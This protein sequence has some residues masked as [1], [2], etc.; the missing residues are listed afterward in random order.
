[1]NVVIMNRQ[2]I[3]KRGRLP[4][5]ET[6]AVISITDVDYFFAE[7][8]NEP[9]HRLKLA[10]DDVDGDV[11]LDELSTGSTKE[12]RDALRRKYHMFS[13]E[14]AYQIAAFYWKL[15]TCGVDTLIVQCEHGQSRSAAVAA[16]IR[17]FED[18]EGISIFADDRYWP[19]KVVFRKTLKALR[20][21][22]A[23]D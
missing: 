1:M 18:K 21:N 10:F 7:L 9:K 13:D 8:E 19:N 6:T 17:E 16:A 4:F 2:S 14:Q 5:P 11:F 15:I 23:V 20:S 12:E 3:E 22:I